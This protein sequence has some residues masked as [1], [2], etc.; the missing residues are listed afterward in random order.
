[1]TGWVGFEPSTAVGV[2]SNE[3]VAHDGSNFL[4]ATA[5]VAGGSVLQDV[6]VA[7]AS[8]QPF[9]VSSWFRAGSATPVSGQLCAWQLGSSWDASCT[10]FT[11]T[12][13]GWVRASTI[14]QT[15][16]SKSLIRVQVYLGT[17]NAPVLMDTVSALRTGDDVSGVGAPA[18]PPS[19]FQP[20]F[21]G[22]AVFGSWFGSKQY[23]RLKFNLP[24]S[25]TG[26]S[27]NSAVLRTFVRNCD[28]KSA[29][30]GNGQLSQYANPIHVRRMVADFDTSPESV[31]GDRAVLPV[32]FTSYANAD[33]TEYVT[34][35]AA[36]PGSN[37]GVRLDM[38]DIAGGNYG[39]CKVASRSDEFAGDLN[40]TSFLEVT[41][42]EPPAA[43]KRFHPINPV[44][45]M[46]SAT[47]FGTASTGGAGY[48]GGRWVTVMGGATGVPTSGVS[49]VAVS[50]T[51]TNRSVGFYGSVNVYPGGP[52]QP[53][54]VASSWGPGALSV[55][56]NQAVVPIGQG[57]QIVADVFSGRGDVQIDITGWFDDGTPATAVG[58]LRYQPQVGERIAD[59]RYGFG[60]PLVGGVTR[61]FVVLG[62]G[63]VP[64]AGVGAVGVQVHGIGSGSGGG[65]RVK[66]WAVGD[67]EPVDTAALVLASGVDQ[68]SALMFVKVGVGG[69]IN[70]KS[71][72]G[73]TVVLD[74][75]G[76]FVSSATAGAGFQPVTPQRVYDSREVVYGGVP[77]TDVDIRVSDGPGVGAVLVN[78]FAYQTNGPALVDVYPSGESHD[79]FDTMLAN[80]IT[81]SLA[82]VRPS[83][84][85]RIHVN[86]APGTA[87]IIVDLVGYTGSATATGFST[88]NVLTNG[89]FE[90]GSAPWG[91]NTSCG[92]GAGGVSFT[93]VSG[94]ATDLADEGTRYARVVS[95]STTV[96]G[97]LCQNVNRSEVPPK[98]GDRYSLRFR[99]RSDPGQPAG[100][101]ML[102]L[103]E[104]GNAPSSVNTQQ[105]FITSGVW[106]EKTLS[107]CASNSSNFMLRT[108]IY[109][110][111]T[112]PLDVDNVRLT[113]TKDPACQLF[114]GV[115][116]VA[117]LN[118]TLA[119]DSAL[120]WP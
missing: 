30:T 92:D 32:G 96:A 10:N 104:L 17:L 41:Y 34:G 7:S 14:A 119:T 88:D 69:A 20:S 79:N 9:A 93:T 63:G 6:A 106:T 73:L 13:S 99:V 76:Y 53:A 23:S 51:A 114:N 71:S 85:G 100:R 89:S 18:Y 24:P 70:V 66:V 54:A 102:E 108:K 115:P 25:L 120:P 38:G 61:Q 103:W 27:V 65:A 42:N 83:A 40:K 15:G 107:M 19:N 67:V 43:T 37:Y 110:Y 81:T 118:T 78:V 35:W 44:T 113:I 82:V 16:A 98:A 8:G 3:P 5:T 109:P 111:G 50:I 80:D 55:A 72:A 36:D 62:Q 105:P 28:H 101:G 29:G 86:V 91:T 77:V 84:D 2:V 75:M 1:M 116:T 33:I 49:A 48:Q 39:Y 59:T 4:Q 64:G 90:V 22:E 117:D 45:V 21:S 57:N 97:S 12:N 112:V 47:G 74:A 68:R 56:A 58:G 52:S 94:A 60:G 31:Q 46:N 87:H 26:A 11:A 95:T